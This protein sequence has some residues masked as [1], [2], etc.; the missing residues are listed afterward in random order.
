MPLV[1]IKAA[2]FWTFFLVTEG[3]NHQILKLQTSG[4]F[5]PLTEGFKHQVLKLQTSGCFY[6]VTEGFNHQVLKLQTSGNSYPVTEGFKAAVLT[7]NSLLHMVTNNSFHPSRLLQCC[8][9]SK[10]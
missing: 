1:W 9:K 7:T 8:L 2:D 4:H 10:G 5:Y 6:L 3:F